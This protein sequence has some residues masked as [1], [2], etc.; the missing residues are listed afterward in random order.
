[1]TTTTTTATAMKMRPLHARSALSRLLQI[2][3]Q[4]ERSD[5]FTAS[6]GR[7][8]RLVLHFRQRGVRPLDCVPFATKSPMADIPAVRGV[9]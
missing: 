1:M 7:A 8:A 4:C 3:L 5:A 2:L 9:M 6:S